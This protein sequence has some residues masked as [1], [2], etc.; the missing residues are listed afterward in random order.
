MFGARWLHACIAPP[1]EWVLKSLC[2]VVHIGA[3][4]FLIIRRW[5]MDS[6]FYYAQSSSL[7]SSTIKFWHGVNIHYQ[8]PVSFS[9][10]TLGPLEVVSFWLLYKCMFTQVHVYTSACLHKCLFIQAWLRWF[11]FW[12]GFLLHS[13]WGTSLTE[14]CSLSWGRRTGQRLLLWAQDVPWPQNLQPR[15]PISGTSLRYVHDAIR[16]LEN[17]VY[18]TL[19]NVYNF[20][21][22]NSSL[23]VFKHLFICSWDELHILLVYT[24]QPISKALISNTKNIHLKTDFM[25]C[26]F[27]VTPPLQLWETE[28]GSV[29]TTR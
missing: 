29:T 21:E 15:Y 11:N 1:T 5:F 4:K 13:V 28:K 24:L 25:F 3:V 7:I 20:G 10:I 23:H 18:N 17:P 12:Y 16:L 2:V 27:P 19:R 14:L 6:A 8:L 26:R 9:D 22:K